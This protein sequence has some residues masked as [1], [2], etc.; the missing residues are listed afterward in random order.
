[1]R[2]FAFTH[3]KPDARVVTVTGQDIDQLREQYEA[4]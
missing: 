3:A 2:R 4:C 1:M